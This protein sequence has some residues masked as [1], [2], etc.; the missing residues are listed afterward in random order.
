MNTEPIISVSG[1]RGI[2]GQSLTPENTVKYVAAYAAWLT[3]SLPAGK[4]ASVIVARDGRDSGPMLMQAVTSTL[5]ACG[6]NVKIAD[7]AATPTVGVL[8]R[9][10]QADGAVQIS[11]SHNPPPYNGMKLFG[12]DGR[13]IPG[14]QGGEVKRLYLEGQAD[15][16]SHEDL[17]ISQVLGDTTSAHLRKVLSTVDVE[18]IREKNFRVVLDSNQASGSL[19]GKELLESLGCEVTLVGAFP[20]GQFLHP[21]EPTEKNLSSVTELARQH[22]AQVVFCQDPDADRLAIIDEQGTYIGE[23]YTLAITLA[24]ALSQNPGPVV[25]NCSSS[26]MT[27]DL[28]KK[29]GVACHLS[30]VGEANVTDLMIEV[31][32]VYGG[33]GSGGP[34]DPRVGFVRDSFV[35]MAQTLDAMAKHEQTVSQLVEKLPRYHIHKTTVSLSEDQERESAI[36][37]AFEKLESAFAQHQVTKQD[38]LRVDWPDAWLLVRPSNTEPIIRAIAEAKSADRAEELCQQARAI[39]ERV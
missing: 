21:P 14:A 12:H 28:A 5:L 30:K 33:E 9:E 10:L 2:V 3:Q 17:G 4:Q 31:G 11:A 23:E 36:A 32:A 16:V 27:V 39:V 15:W 18:A 19:L 8:V 6:V 1:L 37:S 26:R 22:Q 20:D 24:H 34:I 35:G 38:G 25:T 29:H 7:I 13:V